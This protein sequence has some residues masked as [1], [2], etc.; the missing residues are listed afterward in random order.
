MLQLPDAGLA[1]YI[2]SLRSRKYPSLSNK[3]EVLMED[4][5]AIYGTIADRTKDPDDK[6]LV[7]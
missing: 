3:P 6:E 4:L 7:L 2:S 1:Y 5:Y